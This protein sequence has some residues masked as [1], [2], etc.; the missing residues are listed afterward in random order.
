MMNSQWKDGDLIQEWETSP[1]LGKLLT[2]CW[3]EL[4]TTKAL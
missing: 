4:N 1:Y 3:K 2:I